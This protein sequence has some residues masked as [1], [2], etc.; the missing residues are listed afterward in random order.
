MPNEKLNSL[1]NINHQGVIAFKSGIIYQDLQQVVDW[2]NEKGTTALFVI[3]DG[4]TDV[5]NIGAIARTAVCCRPR[6]S[7]F[8]IK[9]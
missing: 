6:R 1:T 2:V 7:L 5:R 9:V 3:L 8:P 4:I